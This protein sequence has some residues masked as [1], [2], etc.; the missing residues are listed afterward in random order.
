MLAASAFVHL[1]DPFVVVD[2]ATSYNWQVLVLVLGPWLWFQVC[3]LIFWR[4]V[5]TCKIVLGM[6]SQLVSCC[7]FSSFLAIL[8]SPDGF[9]S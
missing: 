5:I 3:L 7:I 8:S 6:C 4:L 9:F 1:V 2:V